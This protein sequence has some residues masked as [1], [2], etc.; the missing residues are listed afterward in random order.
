[1]G[2]F[3]VALLVLSS[4]SNR[5]YQQDFLNSNAAPSYTMTVAI[6]PFENLTT[7]RNA[8]LIVSEIMNTELLRRGMFN[9]LEPSRVRKWM[10]NNKINHTQVTET[11]YA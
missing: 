4:C 5:G 10:T 2:L 3:S 9:I 6:V 8:G 7:H 11:T 1:M